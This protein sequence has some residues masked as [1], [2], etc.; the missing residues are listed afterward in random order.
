MWITLKERLSLGICLSVLTKY[1]YPQQLDQS[2]WVKTISFIHFTTFG[3]MLV[4]SIH[5]SDHQRNE[6]L[7]HQD[8]LSSD[9][10][11]LS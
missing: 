4:K 1:E 3:K 9:L 11:L 10:F 5:E 8:L 2:T 7:L 6:N